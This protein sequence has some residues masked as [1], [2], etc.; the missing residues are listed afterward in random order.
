MSKGTRGRNIGESQGPGRCSCAFGTVSMVTL[1]AT[2]K[3]VQATTSRPAGTCPCQ[4]QERPCALPHTSKWS[5][6]LTEPGHELV[7]TVSSPINRQMMV[8][9]SL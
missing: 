3:M 2:G 8:T 5:P 7:L 4:S 1:L 9:N 6:R